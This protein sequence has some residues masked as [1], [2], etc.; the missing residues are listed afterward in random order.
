MFCRKD[1]GIDFSMN[2]VDTVLFDSPV[3]MFA[4]VNKTVAVVQ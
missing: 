3:W 1:D 2:R 4:L